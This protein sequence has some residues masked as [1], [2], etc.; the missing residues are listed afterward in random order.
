MKTVKVLVSIGVTCTLFAGVVKGFTISGT[1]N[2]GYYGS[3]LATQV[4]A[5]TAFKD[6]LGLVDQSNGS[7]LDAAYGVINNGVVYLFF[8]GNLD[9]GS[10]GGNAYDKLHVFIMGDNGAGGDNTLGTNYSITADF[11]QLNRMGTGGSKALVIDSNTGTLTPGLTFDA[12][13]NAN[14]DIEV[15]AGA[16]NLV[17]M[18][19]NYFQICPFC[20]GYSLGSVEPTNTP[21]NILTDSSTLNSGIQVV[22]NNSNTN[23]VW[24]GGG[25]GC[26]ITN[27]GSTN[28]PLAVT[29]GVEMAIPLTAI[30]SPQSSVSIC[31]FISDNACDSLY[32]Q[33]LSPISSNNAYFCDSNIDGPDFDSSEVNFTT[34]TVPYIGQHYFT[35]T[36]PGCSSPSISYDGGSYPFIA[37]FPSTGGSSNV[38]VASCSYTAS[39]VAN[40]VTIT[41]GASGSTNTINYTVGE[42]TS[43]SARTAD[44]FIVTPVSSA[45]VTQ[46]VTIAEDGI[47]L[48]PLGAITT[49]GSWKSYYGC[50]LAV[51]ALGTPW[52]KSSVNPG[53]VTFGNDNGDNELDAAYGLVQNDTLFL[54]FTGNLQN[55]FGANELHIFFMAGAGGIT[56]G[57]TSMEVTNIGANVL[58][59]MGG[60]TNG[61]ATNAVGP[62][63]LFDPGF[64]PNYWMGVNIGSPYH[65]YLDY[66]QLWPGG[67]NAAGIATNG[68]FVGSS[69]TPTNGTLVPSYNPF[70]IQATI[71]NSNTNGVAGDSHGC[72]FTG[73]SPAPVITN[74]VVALQ[75][76]NGVELAIPLAALGGPTG[77]IGVC[78]FIGNYNGGQPGGYVSNQFLPPV[79]TNGVCQGPL[80]TGN[81][82][83]VNLGAL[84]GAPHFFTVGPEMRVTGVG[85]AVSGGTTNVSVTVLPE[86]NANISYRLQR[87]F[88]PLTTNSTWAN[89]SG[90][91]PANGGPSV[92]TFTDTH[93]TNKV[94]TVGGILYRVQQTPACSVP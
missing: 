92:I 73:E 5:T 8:A 48:P 86:N 67:T 44:L 74:S 9:T 61:A 80:A 26:V 20:P 77:T 47:T 52:G 16:T 63:F 85:Y 66:A 23:G 81:S 14:Y 45:E 69:T 25:G 15:L 31:A 58:N 32:N 65:F 6:S 60:S 68:Y 36:V 89:V 4:L 12:G 90:A 43:I 79:G 91:S 50:P 55:E 49:D 46:T 3:A 7:E 27:G 1:L 57:L 72:A 59:V 18:F 28:N 40:W 19:A 11:G 76:T 88:A 87:T 64:K 62:G 17:T 51:Q 22:L 24:A 84:P 70:G 75:A 35:I 56:N 82:K 13:F 2:Q 29:T 30:G 37:S 38:N 94:G 93:A 34:V 53:S 33:V 83:N 54:L 41:S 21:S 42:N 71:N 10:S 78:A 39:T